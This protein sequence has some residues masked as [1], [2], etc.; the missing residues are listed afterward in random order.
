MS[1]ETS[2]GR[3]QAGAAAWE[4]LGR[5]IAQ[6]RREQGIRTQRELAGRAGVSLKTVSNCETGRV[7]ESVGVPG[8]Y[9]LIAGVLGWPGGAVERV[10]AGG[11]VH[12]QSGGGGGRLGVVLQPV[13][14]LVD[15]ARDAGAPPELVRRVRAE[16]LE[17]ALWAV[18]PGRQ[19]HVK[20]TRD[21]SPGR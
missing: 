20:S 5:L 14:E 17:V 18:E 6:S 8:S 10:L 4:R 12:V 21:V 7:P 15:R 13:H 19:Q 9:Y 3:G 11:E 16:M 2:V 1:D